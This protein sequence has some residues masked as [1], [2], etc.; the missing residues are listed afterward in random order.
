M[1]TF[2]TV[3]PI[4]TRLCIPSKRLCLF[5]HGCAPSTRLCLFLHGCAYFYTV[6]HLPPDC[7]YFYTVV[8]SQVSKNNKRFYVTSRTS[9][10]EKHDSAKVKMADQ[11]LERVTVAREFH[12]FKISRVNTRRAMTI[13][14]R[15]RERKHFSEITQRLCYAANTQIYCSH[16]IFFCFARIPLKHEILLKT[17]LITAG[18]PPR[19]LD[20]VQQ[21]ANLIP[22]TL[23]DG[24]GETGAGDGGFR[25]GRT[26]RSASKRVECSGRPHVAQQ[27]RLKAPVTVASRKYAPGDLP[28]K[29]AMP[30]R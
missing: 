26:R 2:H 19:K 14:G 21:N 25:Q 3:V 20:E 18:R 6:V 17:T 30:R 27:V 16:A 13:P 15:P 24:C 8:P 12:E 4:S 11:F 10:P 5:L 28:K 23:L 1:H 29:A 7:A 9:E 22:H